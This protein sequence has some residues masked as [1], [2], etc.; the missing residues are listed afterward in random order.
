MSFYYSWQRRRAVKGEERV[1]KIA[2]AN[3]SLKEK[4]CR[5]VQK[6]L[7]TELDLVTLRSNRKLW[8]HLKNCSECARVWT[9]NLRIKEALQRAVKRETAPESLRER[10]RKEVSQKD[11]SDV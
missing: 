3:L 5:E 6:L 1:Q 10:L 4:T 2:S 11:S 7:N 9:D 8:R